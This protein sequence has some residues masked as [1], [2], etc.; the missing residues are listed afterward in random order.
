MFSPF[1]PVT[2]QTFAPAISPIDQPSGQDF[3]R[4][5]VAVCPDHLKGTPSAEQR[6]IALARLDD[7]IGK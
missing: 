4:W 6:A 5:F 7:P 2:N 3:A 1:V